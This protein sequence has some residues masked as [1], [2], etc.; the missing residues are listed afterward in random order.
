M[1]DGEGHAPERNQV[2]TPGLSAEAYAD[3][4]PVAGVL[5]PRTKRPD[6]DGE[7]F[8]FA[9][10]P[11]WR[12]RPGALFRYITN[13]GGGW[14]PPLER[15]VGAVLRDVRD[16][17]VSIDAARRVYGVVIVGDPNRDPEGLLVDREATAALRAELS[18]A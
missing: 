11:T 2:E 7:Y 10:V 4:T 17:Y 9:R 5:D 13:G 14:G 8:A 18:G 15:D 16:E 3:S 1:W 6:R 12:T